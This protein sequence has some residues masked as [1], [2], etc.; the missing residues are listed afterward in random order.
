MATALLRGARAG[1][2]R[3]ADRHVTGVVGGGVRA[4]RDRIV[5]GSLAPKYRPEPL[6]IASEAKPDAIAPWLASPPPMA[7]ASVLLAAAPL[8][9]AGAAADGD[10]I[11]GARTGA[12]RGP[13]AAA[14]GDRS[15]AARSGEGPIG[16]GAD[17][18]RVGPLSIGGGVVAVGD[19]AIAGGRGAVAGGFAV[20]AGRGGVGAGGGRLDARR[21]R[22]SASG[23]SVY[24]GRRGGPAAGGGVDARRRRFKAGSIGARAGRRREISVRYAEISSRGGESAGGAAAQT[25]GHGLAA[26]RVGVRPA[27]RRV[28][29]RMSVAPPALPAAKPCVVELPQVNASAGLAMIAAPAAATEASTN[30]RSAPPASALVASNARCERFSVCLLAM[31]DRPPAKRRKSIPPITCASTPEPRL[32]RPTRRRLVRREFMTLQNRGSIN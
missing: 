28:G 11:V 15:R 17:A 1:R 23:V 18:R 32:P 27:R 19:G 5:A 13:V 21:R 14:D 10:R 31:Q 25:V 29:S 30:P 9:R 2:A 8:R 16:G 24:A 12:R 22:L 4:E 7:I 20:E 3:A 6:P 26:I